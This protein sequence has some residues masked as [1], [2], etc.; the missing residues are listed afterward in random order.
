MTPCPTDAGL[1]AGV[2][3]TLLSDWLSQS[4]HMTQNTGL[5]EISGLEKRFVKLQ[6]TGSA[7]RKLLP[8]MSFLFYNK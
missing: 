7:N 4:D 1:S 6:E 5:V 2:P 8:T 3:R